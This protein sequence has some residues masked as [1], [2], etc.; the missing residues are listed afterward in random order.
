MHSRKQ[1]GRLDRE[2]VYFI[3]SIWKLSWIPTMWKITR[4]P[5]RT[6][7]CEC[8]REY[9]SLWLWHS[10]SR[11]GSLV[12]CQRHGVGKLQSPFHSSHLSFWQYFK[13]RK[14]WVHWWY[15]LFP[16]EYCTETEYSCLGWKWSSVIEGLGGETRVAVRERKKMYSFF[17]I[18]WLYC[19]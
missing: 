4:E 9:C 18:F 13:L 7:V 3:F 6:V 17:I 5:C 1:T 14:F 19:A 2:T 10:I 11:I 16:L 15:T 12:M 8:S